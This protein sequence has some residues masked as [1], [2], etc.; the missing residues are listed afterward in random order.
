MTHVLRQWALALARPIH[1]RLRSQKVD[2]FREYLSAT[3]LTL[4]DVGGGAGIAGEFIQLYSYFSSVVMANLE[5][6]LEGLNGCRILPVAADGRQLPFTEKSFDWVFSNAVI[7]HVGDYEKQRV[8]AN[9]IRRVAARGY[10]V[11]TPNK[12]FPIEPHSLL[13]FYQF[14]SPEWQRR[15]VRFSPGYMREYEEIHLLSAGQMQSLFPEAKIIPTGVPLFRNSLV[16]CYK[17]A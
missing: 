4:L 11:T 8:F 7:E 10:F 14:L 1:V 5:P 15:V 6:S 9:E 13:P 2:L 3:G 12:Y 16:A 17:S